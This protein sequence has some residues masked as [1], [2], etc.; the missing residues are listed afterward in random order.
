MKKTIITLVLALIS[1]ATVMAKDIRV[2]VFQVKKMH[3]ENCVKKITNNIRF[4]KGVKDIAA[5]LDA[6]EVTVTYDA[7]TNNIKNLQEGFKKINYEAVFIKES[8]KKEEQK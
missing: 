5:N 7:D 1:G 4:E 8:K 3:C 6:H 2:A